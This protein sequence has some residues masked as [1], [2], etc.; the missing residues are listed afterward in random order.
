MRKIFIAVVAVGIC[1]GA[2][3][4]TGEV[5]ASHGKGEIGTKIIETGDGPET[6]RHSKVTVHYTGWLEDGTKFD[7]SLDRGE[8]FNFTLGTGSVIPGWDIGIEGMK[9]GE[10]RELIIPPAFAYGAKGAGGVIPPNATLRFE[11]ELLTAVPPKYQN[12]DSKELE[13]LLSRGVKI[14]DIRRPDEW[15]KTGI[16]EGSRRLTAFDGK[17]HFVKSF[18]TALGKFAKPDDEI[19]L[20]CRTGNRSAVLAQML[21]EQAEYKQVYNVKDGIVKWIEEKKPV[22]RE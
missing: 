22:R 14:M 6:V 15:R 3:G 19:I 8:P 1:F 16:V 17:G 10:K 2:M 7:S 13:T 12:I 11:V 18:P 4:V 9:P 21:T 20:I 5:R